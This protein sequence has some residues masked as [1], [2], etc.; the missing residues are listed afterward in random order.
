[1]KTCIECNKE[2]PEENFHVKKMLKSGKV[3]RYPRCKECHNRVCLERQ[4]KNYKR[5]EQQKLKIDKFIVNGMV[6]Y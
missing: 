2:Y 3:Y 6:F 1:M 5:K 4:K